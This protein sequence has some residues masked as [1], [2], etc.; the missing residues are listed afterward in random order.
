MYRM[1]CN[2]NFATFIGLE[3][4]RAIE[5]CGVDFSSARSL[6]QPVVHRARFH[7]LVGINATGIPRH[8]TKNLRKMAKSGLAGRFSTIFGYICEHHTV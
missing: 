2:I 7:M 5:R 1:S 3:H 4:E 6:R 8:P